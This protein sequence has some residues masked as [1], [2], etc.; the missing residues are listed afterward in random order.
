MKISQIQ[1]KAA[2]LGIDPGK[3]K[4]DELIRS[5]QS[6]EG[7]EACFQM[8]SD[9]CAQNDCCWKKDCKPVSLKI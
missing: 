5:I 7:N 1:S 3:M 4:K 8:K 6:K 2:G 9:P